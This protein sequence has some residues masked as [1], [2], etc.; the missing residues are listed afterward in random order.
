[1]KLLVSKSKKGDLKELKKLLCRI[2]ENDMSGGI[3]ETFHGQEMRENGRNVV[4]ILFNNRTML[5]RAA[6][7]GHIN[8]CKYLLNKEKANVDV[9]QRKKPGWT[10]LHHACHGLEYKIAELLICKGN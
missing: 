5:M 8:I 6:E 3:I 10:A 2:K 9:Q 1:M 4:D 7:N